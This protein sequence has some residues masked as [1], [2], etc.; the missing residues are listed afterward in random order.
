LVAFA[1]IWTEWTGVRGTKANPVAGSYL[2]Y[3]F[4]TT[5]P[6]DVVAPV[7]PK[8]MLVIL[9]SPDEC[10]IWLHAVGGSWQAATSAAQHYAQDRR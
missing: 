5:E 3:G 6:N 10:D 4:L 2:L 7:H 9:T 8:A 1:G